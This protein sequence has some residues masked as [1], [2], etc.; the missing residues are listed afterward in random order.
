M[1]DIMLCKK[2]KKKRL[3][4]VI[5]I[6]IIFIKS[7]QYIF[8]LSKPF[9]RH[10]HIGSQKVRENSSGSIIVIKGKGERASQKITVYV[11]SLEG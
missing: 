2:A 4:E 7:T 9:F 11:F 8:R 3:R 6:A 10:F 1:W 5:V